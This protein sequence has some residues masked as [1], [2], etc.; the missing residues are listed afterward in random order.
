M[1]RGPL[2]PSGLRTPFVRP[3]GREA[4]VGSVASV[5]C[6]V[7]V[8]LFGA[9]LWQGLWVWRA[10]IFPQWRCWL[11][12]VL[13]VV[14]VR[15]FFGMLFRIGLVCVS[16]GAAALRAAPVAVHGPVGVDGR[17]AAQALESL[18][19]GVAASVGAQDVAPAVADAQSVPDGGREAQA[20]LLHAQAAFAQASGGA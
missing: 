10:C 18:L 20:A 15:R 19:A 13:S 16:A 2:V 14:F 9:C 6:V 11:P 3:S 8:R 5:L 7:C 1:T 17:A 12:G 4:F